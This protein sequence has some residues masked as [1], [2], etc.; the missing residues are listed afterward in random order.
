M[1][2]RE[3][4]A[5]QRKLHVQGVTQRVEDEFSGNT[6]VIGFFGEEDGL[7]TN[8]QKV[9]VKVKFVCEVFDEM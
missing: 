6:I 1:V 7:V 5:F 9:I 2:R 8:L 3:V 4:K